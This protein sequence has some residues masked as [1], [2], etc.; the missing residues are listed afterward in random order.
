M[1]ADGSWLRGSPRILVVDAIRFLISFAVLLAALTFWKARGGQFAATLL[2]LAVFV[3]LPLRL[4][5]IVARWLTERYL[6]GAEHLH[7]RT[8]IV[9]RRTRQLG[10][11]S[12]VTVDES[13]G[14]LLRLFRL[15]QLSLLQSDTLGGSVRF[16]ALTRSAAEA[17]RVRMP[18]DE[19]AVA[20]PGEAPASAPVYRATWRELWL[21]SVVNGRFALLAAPVL[22][23]VWNLVERF[24]IDTWL[25][26]F[27]GQFPLWIVSVGA[28]LGFLLAGALATVSKYQDF[29][30]AYAGPRQLVL[31]YGLLEKK[32]RKIAVA[33][34]A[35]VTIRRSLVEQALGRA[36]LGILTLKG[37][38]ELSVGVVLPSLPDRVVEEITRSHF[39]EFAVERP[40][41]A[42]R[43][44]RV[45]GRLLAAAAVFAGPTA[46]AVW[47]LARGFGPLP[48]AALALLLLFL[49]TALGRLLVSRIDLG[50]TGVVALR[51]TLVSEF[52]TRVRA[53]SIHWLES[54][55][56][57][58]SPRPFRVALA[59]YAGGPGT[60]T[61]LRC[62]ASTL[63]GIRERM[64]LVTES[65]AM[66]QRA[67]A[68]HLAQ[69][70][71]L[72]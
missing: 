42:P 12:I 70:R 38:D 32:E 9:R 65:V 49:V 45:S 56:L 11:G 28:V 20:E 25:V 43:I 48:T 18:G 27:V 1:T 10:W 16:R 4:A 2:S 55:H 6:L 30:I 63:G 46:L 51:H 35:G 67:G 3:Y 69:A 50:L 57:R 33:S 5:W 44:L 72:P 41:T 58:A 29:S 64:A 31:S 66:R 60:F 47:L 62:D 61:A 40:Q 37:T 8:G 15:R 68:R 22:L 26:A 52:D 36:R 54:S 19:G 24:G 21:M 7:V 39:G 17:V 53:G 23:G 34:I 71:P 59:Y 14:L 13:A